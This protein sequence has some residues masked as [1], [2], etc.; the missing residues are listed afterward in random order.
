MKKRK[1]G[2]GVSSSRPRSSRN[3][4][5]SLCKQKFYKV[6]EI[7]GSLAFCG[8]VIFNRKKIKPNRQ[9]VVVAILS[10]HSLMTAFKGR[11]EVG[12]RQWD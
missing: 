9:E 2:R 6:G 10:P 11:E 1:K 12:R 4:A 3:A 5:G 8:L 7:Y